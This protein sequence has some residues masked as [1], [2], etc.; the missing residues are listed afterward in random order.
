MIP[1]SGLGIT[2][3]HPFTV[4]FLVAVF[5]EAA[6]FFFTSLS[7]ISVSGLWNNTEEYAKWVRP[8]KD[9]FELHQNGCQ[10]TLLCCLWENVIFIYL[11]LPFWKIRSILVKNIRSKVQDR[12][13]LSN[14]CPSQCCFSLPRNQRFTKLLCLGERV[15]PHLFKT[16][17]I[18]EIE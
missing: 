11:Q 1:T 8:E 12:I 2:H 5:E 7:S 6:A 18:I 15:S 3:P 10:A 16:P 13:F 14:F 4:L 9:T 17:K